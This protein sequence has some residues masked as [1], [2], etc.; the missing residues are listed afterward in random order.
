MS[1]AKGWVS[2]FVILWGVPFFLSSQQV[3]TKKEIAVFNLSYYDWNIPNTALG[4]ID[5][6][7]RAVF[8]NMG[9]FNVVG[10]TQRLGVKDVNTFIEKI[11]DYKSRNVQIPERVLMGQEAFTE[12]DW[13]RLVGAFLVVIPSVT[14][15]NLDR[16]RDGSYKASL[17]TSFTIINVEKFQP[18]AQFYVETSGQDRSQNS[19]IKA[20]IDGIPLMLQFQLRKVD[21]FQIRSGIVQIMGQDVI[22][23]LGRNMGIMVGDEFSIISYR[24]IAGFQAVEEV[25]LIIVKEV[26]EQFSVGRVIYYSRR[27][28]V[29]DQIQEIPR[30]GFEAMLFGG[31]FLVDNYELSFIPQL[32]LKAVASRGFYTTRPVVGAEIPLSIATAALSL[33]DIIPMNAYIGAEITNLYLGR[34]QLAP[35]IVVGVGGAYLGETARGFFKTNQEFFMTHAGGKAFMSLSYLASRN[36]KITIDAGYALWLGLAEVLLDVDDKSY[37]ATKIGPFVHVGVTLK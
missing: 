17:Q 2:V 19:A 30:I 28:Q 37:F 34:L 5:E 7:I 21:E 8:I 1:K 15:F 35:T 27:P 32:G 18:T 4:A 16:L 11:K 22:F 29:G 23:E 24:T 3:S 36:T 31:A 14:Y 10:L 33:F 6:Q 26:Q 9:R 20:A 13:N 12:A 25:G